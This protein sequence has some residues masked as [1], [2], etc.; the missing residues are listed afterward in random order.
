MRQPWVLITRACAVG[1]DVLHWSGSRMNVS[2]TIEGAG[3][4]PGKPVFVIPNRVDMAVLTALEEMLGGAEKIVWLVEGNLRPAAEI[5]AYME[6][7][8]AGGILFHM[9]PAQRERLYVRIHAEFAVGRHVVLLPGRPVQPG[10]CLADVSAELLRFLLDGYF[11][12]VLPVYAG[13]YGRE[14]LVTTQAP[15]EKL[16]LRPLPM[17]PPGAEQA[18]GVMAAWM[19]ASASQVGRELAGST[20]TLP[21][22][23]LRSLLANPQARIID[24]VDDSAI[25]YRQLLYLAA[26]L[27]RHLRR[28]TTSKRMGVILPPGKLS[29]TAN[30]ACILAGITPVNI[31]YSYDPATLRCAIERAELTRFITEHCFIH[32]QQHFAWPPDRDLIFIDEALSPSGL[33][34]LSKWNL[35]SKW[36]TTK[37]IASWIRTPATD[38]QDEALVVFSRAEDGADIIGSSLSHRAVLAGAAL[39]RS[40]LGTASGQRVLSAL[41]YHHRA[42]LLTG[43]IHPLLLGQDII[44]YPL[45]GSGKRLCRLARQYGP[46][47][48]M[49]SPRQARSVLEQ[50][51][52]GDFAPG[53]GLY[54]AGRV[55]EELVSRAYEKFRIY[56]CECYLPPLAAMPIAC[57]MPPPPTEGETAR[58]SIPTGAPGAV[59][60]PLPGVAIRI[61]DIDHPDTPLPLSSPGLVWVRSAALAGH[62]GQSGSHTHERWYCTGNVGCVRPDGL[63]AIGGVRTRFS[64]IQGEILSH[65]EIEKLMVRFLRVEEKPGEPCIAIVG[66]PTEEGEQL[67][68]LST[69]HDV[70]GPHDAITLRYDITNAHYPSHWAPER[71]VRVNAIPTLP[72]G[73][74]DYAMCRAIA[75]RALQK[76][77]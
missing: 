42:G 11:G 43:L 66:V 17:V 28:H 24:G 50:A 41:P 9:A 70:V 23:L 29:I 31:D 30:V 61:T 53:S 25:N 10:A 45:P 63:L 69:V 3:H 15:C 18:D 1:G 19:E 65:T 46:T 5:A 13:M 12:V 59:G 32:M 38:A 71:I 49:F 44:T 14:P 54:V 36:L 47:M 74:A 77:T 62:L 21:Q 16:L 39:C 72:G 58:Y 27:A 56:L 51:A 8:R 35:L 33:R 2:A 22:A 75:L 67:V 76:V 60:M 7:K 26:P 52:E 73:L 55:P 4:V 48:A 68:L 64:K 34:M 37:R 6:K 40:R 20:D 57:N